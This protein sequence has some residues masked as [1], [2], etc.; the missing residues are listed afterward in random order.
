MFGL[1]FSEMLV[2]AVLVIVVVGPDDLPKL[3]STVGRY[4]AKIRR[5]SDDL[6]RAFNAEIARVEGDQRRDQLKKRKEELEKL[7]LVPPSDAA[8]RPV[9]KPATSTE[10]PLPV[11]DPP[12]DDQP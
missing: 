11:A 7:G 9:R 10:V 3:M 1:D 12:A 5:M 6:R 4:Y 2:I 8:P